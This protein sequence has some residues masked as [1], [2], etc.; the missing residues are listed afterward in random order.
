MSKCGVDLSKHCPIMSKSSVIM[1]RCGAIMSKHCL[2]KSK[3]IVIMSR[4]GLDLVKHE[5][6]NKSLKVGDQIITLGGIHGEVA[7][8]NDTVLT[9]KI[10]DK[11]KIQLN[12]TS[13]AEKVKT[14]SAESADDKAA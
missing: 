7:A 8:V 12:R 2:I 9:I 10:A 13:V 14:D 6:L 5:E 3:G 11:V 4:C 1:S